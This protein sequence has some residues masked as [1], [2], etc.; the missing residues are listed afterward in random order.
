VEDRREFQGRGARQSKAVSRFSSPS[1]HALPESRL[2]TDPH[3]VQLPRILG[4]QQEPVGSAHQLA[5]DNSTL[6]DLSVAL[7]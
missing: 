6:T 4:H 3:R 7:V 5:P 1:G 2:D